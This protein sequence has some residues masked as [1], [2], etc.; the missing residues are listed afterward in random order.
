MTDTSRTLTPPRPAGEAS[1]F[2][3][4]PWFWAVL[5]GLAFLMPIFKALRAELPDAPP[6]LSEPLELALRDAEGE[7][8]ALSDLRGRLVIATGV[9]LASETAAHDAIDELVSLQKRLKGVVD[10]MAYLM[11]AHGG[12]TDALGELLDSRTLRKPGNVPAWDAGREALT[13]LREEAGSRTADFL[14]IDRHG[15]LRGAFAADDAS[16]DA[17]VLQTGLLANWT[18]AD[19][20]QAP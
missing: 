7:P 10:V 1:R 8:F 14:L 16:I 17:L 15:R 11:L 6:Y 19:P 9:P 13:R 5:L 4:T 18:A 2:V 3:A 12:G 20:A